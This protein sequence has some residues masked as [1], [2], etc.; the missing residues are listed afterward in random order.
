MSEVAFGA[1]LRRR[2]I[3]A[4]MTLS[5]LAGQL[6]YSKGYLSK[7]ESGAQ[8]AGS[9][10]AR[11]CDAALGANGELAGVL[12]ASG[13]A[14]RG[15]LIAGAVTILAAPSCKPTAPV[16][17][18]ITAAVAGAGS[19]TAGLT[20]LLGHLRAMSQNQPPGMLLPT[21]ELQARTLSALAS[22]AS[23]A[24]RSRLLLL[25][26]RYAEFIGWMYQESG[27][28]QAMTAWTNTAVDAAVQAGDQDMAAYVY[29]RRANAAM[30]Q[31]DGAATVELTRRALSA[32]RGDSPGAQRVRLLAHQ[33]QA[34]GHA[35]LMRSGDFARALDAAEAVAEQMPPRSTVPAP[36]RLGM[37]SVA[38]PKDLVQGWALYDLGRPEAAV[39]GLERHLSLV[40]ASSRR[41]RARATARLALVQAAVGE[42]EVACRLGESALEDARFVDSQTLRHDLRRLSGSLSRFRV[43]PE[44]QSL[45]P[46]LMQEWRRAG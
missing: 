22:E 32:V 38:D 13:V 19:T 41:A 37:S 4:G 45:M 5:A 33:R 14:R 20:D 29:V 17:P 35:L 3:A 39:A 21:L 31:E 30:Y 24:A 42:V 1:E 27:D 15:V 18:P 26:S 9:D 36:I 8:V 28:Q 44:V 25:Y 7:I 6:H 11:R 10:L 40:P 12:E 34:Q 2:R 46:R 23:A 16:A 43:R